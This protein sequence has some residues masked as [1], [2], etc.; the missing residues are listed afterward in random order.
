MCLQIEN[1][2]AETRIEWLAAQAEGV[3]RDLAGVHKSQQRLIT[4]LT[5]EL[6]RRDRLAETQC[7]GD[8]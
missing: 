7:R 2:P 6:S 4:E 3:I 1:A 8:E 5:L